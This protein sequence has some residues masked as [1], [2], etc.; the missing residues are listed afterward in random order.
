MKFW[1][2]DVF[3]LIKCFYW[4]QNWFK[5]YKTHQ[6]LYNY[7]SVKVKDERFIEQKDR[8]IIHKDRLIKQYERKKNERL[9]K[10][11]KNK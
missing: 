2:N 4:F 11:N 5:T 7:L 3:K 10:Q 8:L 9:I 6:Y 1:N